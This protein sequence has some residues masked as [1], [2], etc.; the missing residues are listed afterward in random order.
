MSHAVNANLL[1]KSPELPVKR[2]G[3]QFPPCRTGP[4]ITFIVPTL[5]GSFPQSQLMLPGPRS[6]ESPSPAPSPQVSAPGACRAGEPRKG[7]DPQWVETCRSPPL[8]ET[9]ETAKARSLYT[10]VQ[11]ATDGRVTRS[12]DAA[13]AAYVSISVGYCP[14]LRVEGQLAPGKVIKI[15][16]QIRSPIPHPP[17]R[18]PTPTFPALSFTNNNPSAE[19]VNTGGERSTSYP[20]VGQKEVCSCRVVYNGR[21]TG[22][23]TSVHQKV[24]G[25][26]NFITSCKCVLYSMKKIKICKCQA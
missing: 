24:T 4:S 1:P 25:N 26:L 23:N 22:N 3:N 20:G 13:S 5:G 21:K 11:P 7:S 15:P 2:R 12:Q 16:A 18:P 17:R 14:L 9:P 10:W 8:P 19:N 6:Q